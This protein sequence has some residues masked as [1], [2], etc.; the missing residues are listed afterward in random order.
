MYEPGNP[1]LDPQSVEGFLAIDKDF[2]LLGLSFLP[3]V[4][5]PKASR[6]RERCFAA[7]RDY[8]GTGGLGRASRL[9]RDR[10]TANKRR[11]V[12][13]D[14]IAQF[15]LGMCIGLL[16]TSVPAIGWT[17]CHVQSDTALSG[18]MP[19]RAVIRTTATVNTPQLILD[20][21]LLLESFVKKLLLVQSNNASAQYVLK[22]TPIQG[23]DG[24]PL[25]L[26]RRTPSSWCRRPFITIP[27]SRVRKFSN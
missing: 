13:L 7:F 25:S 11:V 1:L 10:F 6:E 21:P 8:Y 14:G 5:A 2:A 24:G 12:S 22:D 19:F 3:N 9:V 4:L 27:P 18:R 15:N 17:L 26:S 16:V 23:D 20:F